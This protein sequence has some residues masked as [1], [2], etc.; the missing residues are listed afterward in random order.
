LID[1]IRN[2]LCTLCPL[3]ENVKTI[4]VMGNGDHTKRIM[5]VGEAPGAT[6]DE[7]GQPF[8]GKA[9][10]VLNNVLN[11][12]GINRE[13]VYVT[14]IVKCRPPKNR[15]PEQNEITA[16]VSHYL[17]PEYQLIKPKAVLLLGNTAL[18]ALTSLTGGISQHR[19]YIP[20]MLP[21]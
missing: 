18:H 6:E 2:P 20:G 12:V 4:C 21:V 14:N 1:E 9:G 5:I 3:H 10:Q 15:R 11:D 19:G 13:D 8:A 17:I 7:L 16:C